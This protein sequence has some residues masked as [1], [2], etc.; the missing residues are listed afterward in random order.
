MNSTK[1][2]LVDDH[3]LV[4]QGFKVTLE[5]IPSIEVVGT[6]DSGEKALGL[7]REKKPDIVFLDIMLPG[8]N[9]LELLR[10]LKETEES[11]RVIFI[12]ASDSDLYL[13]EA[14]RQGA[15]GYLSKDSSKALIEAA[16]RGALADGITLS[17]ELVKKAF[18]AISQA[19]VNLRK[20]GGKATGV[21]DVS[22]REIDVLRLLAKSKSDVAISKE[23]STTQEA[24]KEMVLSLRKKLGTR[25]RLTTAI[26]AMR[27]GLI[28]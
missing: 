25:D 2:I 8:F 26:E 28:E 5:S 12:T 13:V 22:T 4:L 27:L 3:P 18:G 1:V 10:Q 6:S 14:L 24:V 15:S 16:L 9:G 17:G 7:I 11:L 20:H 19:A 23:L 21:V